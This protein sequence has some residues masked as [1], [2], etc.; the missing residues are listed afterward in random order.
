M[1]ECNFDNLRP[2]SPVVTRSR[3]CTELDLRGCTLHVRALEVVSVVPS[4]NIYQ[5]SWT[6]C[7]II[8]MIIIIHDHDVYAYSRRC[9]TLA[10]YASM[11]SIRY[12]GA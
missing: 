6:F 11:Q 4:A 7:S 10:S 9:L 1:H 3:I 12:A 2:H 5:V 8:I